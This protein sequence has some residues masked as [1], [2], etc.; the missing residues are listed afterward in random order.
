MSYIDKYAEFIT[1]Q[2]K[3]EKSSTIAEN[4]NFL[5]HVKSPVPHPLLK[6]NV[7]GAFASRTH[8]EWR[9]TLPSDQK[10]KP[11]MRSK[12]GGPVADINVDFHKLHP[13]AQKEN[14]DAAHAAW[15]AHH[16]HP[17][18]DEKAAEHVHNEW[19]K[20]NPKSDYN[21]HQHVPYHQLSVHDKE[22]DRKH[23]RLIKTLKDIHSRSPRI[24]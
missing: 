24:Q 21:A 18:N 8:D 12:N 5:G 7:I 13:S 20:R 9:Q 6:S 23:V 15:D 22:L 16:L 10:D 11:R 4:I 3:C 14:L 17:E 1:H 2:R 19:M